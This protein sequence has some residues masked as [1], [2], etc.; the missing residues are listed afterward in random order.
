MDLRAFSEYCRVIRSLNSSG[1]THR[2]RLANRAP[3]QA[4]NKSF[5]QWP[6]LLCNFVLPSGP[7][8]LLL[9]LWIAD[10]QATTPIGMVGKAWFRLALQ[11]Y[12]DCVSEGNRSESTFIRSNRA[13][14]RV[15]PVIETSSLERT[16]PS[17]DIP[18]G[19]DADGRRNHTRAVSD[20]V[21]ADRA[22]PG[23][24]Q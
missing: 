18:P 16:R 14:H 1:P 5:P 10:S 11:F 6:T 2:L 17:R 24:N 9:N 22:L 15:S 8:H 20:P 4:M 21:A 13:G 3:L 12:S 7:E 23:R 19:R